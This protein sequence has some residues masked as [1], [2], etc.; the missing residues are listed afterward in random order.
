MNKK[1]SLVIIPKPKEEIT[2]YKTIIGKDGK[3]TI[4]TY[5]HT[6]NEELKS[7]FTPVE[8]YFV[9]DQPILPNNYYISYENGPTLKLNT[10]IDHVLN[11]GQFKK[12]ERRVYLTEKDVYW[13]YK[14][15]T[16]EHF[17]FAPWHLNQIVDKGFT[18]F[19]KEKDNE[20]NGETCLNC[21]CYEFKEENFTPEKYKE[22][23]VVLV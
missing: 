7:E 12:G 5:E 9:D 14:T 16:K 20:C 8:Y 22:K 19:V 13:F 17:Q 3:M 23:F 2:Q 4:A 21:T 15:D 1:V 6:V 11:K 18:C 10:E